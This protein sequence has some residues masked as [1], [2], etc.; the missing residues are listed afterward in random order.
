MGWLQRVLA[1]L[2]VSR[3]ICTYKISLSAVTN[4]LYVKQTVDILLHDV[5]DNSRSNTVLLRN[6][7]F[8][9]SLEKSS[10][11]SGITWL[12]CLIIRLSAVLSFSLPCIYL[13][14]LK[15][16]PSTSLDNAA[17]RCGGL[18]CCNT[19]YVRCAKTA[20]L[21]DRVPTEAECWSAFIEN[22]ERYVKTNTCV[23]PR[24]GS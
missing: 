5:I 10:T 6:L 19:V 4:W 24:R 12:R 2:N 9:V 14:V 21:G 15:R 23:L 17:F 16:M 18:Y 3:S 7:V 1:H 11:S 8:F 13:K 20:P 22:Q